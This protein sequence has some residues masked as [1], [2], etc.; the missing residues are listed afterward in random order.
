[1]T[2]LATLG[3]WM[4]A[5]GQARAWHN[6]GHMTTARIGWQSLEDW[7][8]SRIARILK[9]HPHYAVYLIRERPAEVPEIEWA[10]LRASLW[11][12]WV[13]PFFQDKTGHPD[14]KEL[15]RKYNRGPWHYINLPVVPPGQKVL[16]PKSLPAADYDLHGEPGHVL[17]ALKKC[18]TILWA[19]DMPD[20]AK[21]IYLCWLLHLIGDLHQPLHA[22][23]LVS[24]QFPQGDMGG[25]LFLVTPKKGAAV[26][27]LHF[28]W[29]A[30]LFTE[31][32]GFK[33]VESRAAE[34]LRDPTLRRDKLPELKATDFESWA[35]ESLQL[36]KDVVYRGGK[37][38]GAARKGGGGRTVTEAPLLPEEYEQAASAVA[39][40][41]MTLA[42]YRIADQLRRVLKKE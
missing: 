42:G 5:P 9:A 23:T 3:L 14:A 37:L 41:R 2:L 4:L 16:A 18:M 21:A 30:L 11:P 1:M 28:Y 24:D 15:T 22:A 29:D 35:Q 34:L 32:A 8:K 19:D 25:N 6:A 17:T 36:S 7:Q 31:G 26:V 38:A 39:R 10:F 40:R 33:E 27:N 20:E 12:D 13:R